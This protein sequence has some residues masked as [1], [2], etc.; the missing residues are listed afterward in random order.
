MSDYVW[1]ITA[2]ASG[3]GEAI[4]F[5]A[6][7]RGHKVIATARNSAKL[8]VLKAAGAAVMDVDVT[9]DDETLA[10]KLSEANAIYGKITH[11]VNAAGYILVGA[12]EEATQK[13][14]FDT[15]NT[16]VLGCFNIA[17]AAIPHLRAAA[18]TRSDSNGNIAL[19]NF[20]SLGSWSSGAAVAHYC[21]TKFAVTGLTEG[22]RDELAPFGID[23]CVVEPGY[24]RTGILVSGNGDAK[25]R[26]LTR[27]E[28]AV[29]E[30]TTTATARSAMEKTNG[31]Q[32]GDVE[33]C[34]RVIVDV[35]T[36]KGG[37]EVP[38]RLVTGTDCLEVV[39]ERCNDTLRLVSKWEDVSSSVMY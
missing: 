30:G 17:R 18:A 25:G 24:T 38:A 22:L 35:M 1:F 6:L 26:V 29:Y 11:V 39:R 16:N 19:A 33:K 3:F 15:Y 20:G 14:V 37:K 34:A 8:S 21:S 28:L 5:E 31:K 32:P 27:R 36:R 2:A 23:V 4:A 9:S 13:E 7:R 10:A 12:I